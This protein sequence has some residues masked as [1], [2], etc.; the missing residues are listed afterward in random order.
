MSDRN[1]DVNETQSYRI[2]YLGIGGHEEE[3]ALTGDQ[4]ALIETITMIEEHG[5]QQLTATCN[6]RTVYACGGLLV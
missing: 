2:T 3:Q 4:H 5:G 1:N 6:D